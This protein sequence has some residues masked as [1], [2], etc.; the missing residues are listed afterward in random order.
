M[1]SRRFQRKTPKRASA[2]TA[3][4]R[5][6]HWQPLAFPRASPEHLCFTTDL[7]QTVAQADFF[8]KSTP[9]KSELKIKLFAEMDNATPT[10]SAG[11]SPIGG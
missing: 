10:D 2:A 7:R 3:I 9:A 6:R 1:S 4:R 5:G 8:Q 11:H